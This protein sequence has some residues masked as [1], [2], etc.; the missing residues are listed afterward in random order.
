[1]TREIPRGAG[2]EWSPNGTVCMSS[3]Q[4]PLVPSAAAAA[5]GVLAATTSSAQL[6][7]HEIDGQALSLAASTS[8][9]AP[10]AG[11]SEAAAAAGHHQPQP[12]QPSPANIVGAAAAFAALLESLVPHV[13][14]LAAG[15]PGESAGPGAA[16]LR[17]CA[18]RCA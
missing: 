5:Q 18:G 15:P 8:A 9:A 17:L 11:P 1:M 10:A 13:S 12:Q 14:R 2:G 16:R 6:H 3:C 4:G 7:P